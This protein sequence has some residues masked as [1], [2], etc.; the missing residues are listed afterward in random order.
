MPGA[1]S[2]REMICLSSCSL[3]PSAG[4]LKAGIREPF[5]GCQLIKEDRAG[6]G[7]SVHRPWSSSVCRLQLN[8][9]QVLKALWKYT[10]WQRK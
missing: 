2:G 9:C 8:V 7:G 5:S 6:G 1:P 10:A 4:T 3:A